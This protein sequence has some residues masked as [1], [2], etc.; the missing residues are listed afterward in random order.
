MVMPPP[1]PPQTKTQI[2]FVVGVLI[3]VLVVGLV[4]VYML[5]RPSETVN[6]QP[7]PTPTSTIPAVSPEFSIQL[8]TGGSSGTVFPGESVTTTV[9]V[10][11][12]HGEAETV[13][14]S[15]DSGS[16][17]IQCSFGAASSRPDFSS[18]LTIT[19]PYYVNAG[20]YSVIIT[21]TNGVVT[22]STS[23]TVVVLSR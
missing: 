20:Y 16:S 5:T 23:Y 9:F 2:I 22:H 19:V 21:G 11:W 15:A 14:L 13:S 17:G 4:S 6:P 1:P 10:K 8:T 12:L 3:V 7:S 18:I